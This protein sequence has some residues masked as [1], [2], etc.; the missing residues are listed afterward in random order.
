MPGEDLEPAPEDHAEQRAQREHEQRC[1]E[2]RFVEPGPLAHQPE[3]P[4]QDRR[5]DDGRHGPA[6]DDADGALR[7]QPAHRPVLGVQRDDPHRQHHDQARRLHRDRRGARQSEQ[8]VGAVEVAGDR[9]HAEAERRQREQGHAPAQVPRTEAAEGD[10]DAEQRQREAAGNAHAADVGE[11]TPAPRPIEGEPGVD[12]EAG[13]RDPL[14]QRRRGDG[15]DDHA[16]HA[17][18]TTPAGGE[19]DQPG[20]GERDADG[21]VRLG[22]DAV[23]E[24]VGEARHV[25]HPAE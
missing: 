6:R 7:S 4:E 15:R 24:P 21:R 5:D 14:E 20:A 23:T 9:E 19:Q 13:A 2:R 10:R 1:A 18:R 25:E 12:A 22:R 11:R 8:H 17:P 3:P 16:D